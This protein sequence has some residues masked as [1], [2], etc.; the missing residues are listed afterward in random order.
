VHWIEAK[1]G[2]LKAWL[3][4]ERR[5]LI[6]DMDGTLSPIV[7]QP[8]AAY[9]T[10][11]NRDLLAALREKLT[12]VAAVSGRAADDLHS[13]IKLDGV[14]YAG[15]H[16]LERWQDGGV[17]VAP[18]VQPYRPAIEQAMAAVETHLSA[19]MMIED[20]GA[21]LS[22]HYRN[23]ADPSAEI[24][25]LQ[26]IMGEI[27]AAHGLKIYEGRMIFEI[28]PPI[29]MNKGTVFR[30][31]IAEYQLDAAIFIG[32]DTTDADALKMAQ[33][34]RADKTCFALGIGVTSDDVPQIV[35]DSADLLTE[36]VPGVEDFLAWLNE[37]A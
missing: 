1:D 37:M 26:P 13:R 18:E 22:V 31:L 23:T 25:R 24:T 11:R 9:P 2:L 35:V 36:G 34:L 33:T 20:K 10:E 6:T 3:S 17:I 32:D 14:V 27:G 12:L 5:G 7:N 29:E 19:G 21:T 28:R 30:D 8:D 15:N 4:H 16:G